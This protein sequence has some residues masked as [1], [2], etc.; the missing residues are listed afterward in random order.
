MVILFLVGGGLG[1]VGGFGFGYG[2][3]FVVWYIFV[4]VVLLLFLFE[5][6]VCWLIG[7]R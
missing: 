5:E 7:G 3:Y 2:V 4:F 6:E 1:Y